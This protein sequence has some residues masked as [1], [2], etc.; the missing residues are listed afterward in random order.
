M[1]R[2]RAQSACVALLT[3]AFCLIA[4]GADKPVKLTAEARADFEWFSGLG[5]PDLKSA[6]LVRVATGQVRREPDEPPKNTYLHAFLIDAKAG[7]FTVLTFD[8]RER[9]LTNTPADQPEFE[10]TGF[11]RLNLRDEADT[12]LDWVKTSK[13]P[14]DAWRPVGQRLSERAGYFLL[15]RACWRQGLE[16][17]AARLY[18]QAGR[19][20]SR[21]AATEIA[22]VTPEAAPVEITSLLAL[23]GARVV[24]AEGGGGAWQIILD[25][26][27]EDPPANS[28]AKSR[29]SVFR[30]NLEKEM[31]GA[32]FWQLTEDF[33]DPTISRAQLL[34]RGRTFVRDFPRSE[35]L[36]R[37]K[38]AV[39]VLA[40]MAEQDKAHARLAGR[41]TVALSP[42][43]RVAELIFQLRDQ[44]GGQTSAAAGCDIFQ[45]ARGSTNTPA[46]QLVRIGYPAVPQL[47]AA[48]GADEFSRTVAFRRSDAFSHTV[49]SVGDCA[50]TILARISGK[51]L[52]PR[53]YAALPA[54]NRVAEA[55]RVMQVWW[56]QLQEKGE[57][58]YLIDATESGWDDALAPAAMLLARYP[59]AAAGPL[60]KGAQ[61]AHTAAIHARLVETLAR[62]DAPETVEYLGRELRDGPSLLS[63]LAAADGLRRRGRPEPV[64]TMLKEW[65]SVDRARGLPADGQPELVRFLATADSPDAIAALSRDS[66]QR[67]VETRVY[68][69]DCLEAN[70]APAAP[71]LSPATSQAIETA[72][73]TGLADTEEM[74]G[75][76]GLRDGRY[77]I[78]PRVSDFA[79]RLLARFWPDRYS[80][81]LSASLKARDRERLECLN[82]WR[83]GRQLAAL[84]LPVAPATPVGTNDAVKV[85][86][87]E[88]ADLN[89]NPTPEFA[90]LVQS[91]KDKPLR[92]DRL[93][94]V[95]ATLAARSETESGGLE[96]RA[97][98]DEDLSG[99][100]IVLRLL[101]G[102]PP[103]R[104]QGWRVH[105]VVTLGH[106]TLDQDLNSYSAG[107]FGRQA[108]SYRG[109][110]WSQLS[111]A[112]TRALSGPP[113][114]PFL[115][116][117]RMAPF[118]TGFGR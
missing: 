34:A 93:V 76:S 9:T 13:L 115:I 68:I 4:A 7:A 24:T 118:S 109:P 103:G 117:V 44:N 80:F 20:S 112:V 25:D 114:L 46:H 66:R 57:K 2:I 17:E 32:L 72:L 87:I 64:S 89:V 28:S 107:F 97:Q 3:G 111:E 102:H 90:A 11:A 42:E 49:L 98:K 91:L 108:F 100:K 14:P 113:T 35:Y 54:T 30:D 51:P 77:F 12:L 73:I 31:A 19:A 26:G 106:R 21:S 61:A 48:L 69:L 110:S 6:P 38:R 104:G 101:P 71:R 75:E 88:W 16:E 84:P 81:D 40:R 22:W 45:D 43:Q 70:T 10:Q 55:R 18:D 85:T 59:E 39:E 95:L 67:P 41:D 83:A 23:G 8:L 27:E 1:S 105:E 92:A 15:S 116:F 56:D 36:P 82:V 60:I 47:I 94:E 58:Q 52:N 99:V 78:N 65:E 33:G 86:G 74:L 53:T 29:A 5:L 62:C 50:L 96:L 37:A 63:R 79:A